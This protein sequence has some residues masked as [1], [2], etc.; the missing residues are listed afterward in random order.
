MGIEVTDDGKMINTCDW[1][2]CGCRE[3]VEWQTNPCAVCIR[4]TKVFL[5]CSPWSV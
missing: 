3:E 4:H 1:P 2:D 5:R